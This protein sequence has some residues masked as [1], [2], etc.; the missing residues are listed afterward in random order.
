[1]DCSFGA[2]SPA[3]FFLESSAVTTRKQKARGVPDPIFGLI[4]DDLEKVPFVYVRKKAD[5]K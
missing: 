1:M 3:V 5:A 2:R 4:A